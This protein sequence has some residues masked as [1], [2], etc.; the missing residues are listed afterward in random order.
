MEPDINPDNQV[1]TCPK[2][3]GF[4]T[5]A[6]GVTYMVSKRG[7]AKRAT[8]KRSQQPTPASD[9]QDCRPLTFTQAQGIEPLP[10]PLALEELSQHARTDLW[11]WLWSCIPH[12]DF[13]SAWGGLSAPEIEGILRL[14]YVELLHAPL[15]LF[16]GDVG[17]VPLI[18][19][20]IFLSGPYNIVFDIVQ[21]IL[22]NSNDESYYPRVRQILRQNMLAYDIIDI[23]PD[24]PTIVPNASPEEGEA[25]RE[26][27][28]VLRTGPFDGARHHLQQAASFINAGDA[29]K[30]VAQAMHAIESVVRVIAP[31]NNFNQALASLN[32]TSTIHPALKEALT[33]LYGYT[34]DEKGIRHPMLESDVARVHMP[35]AVFMYGACAAF[36]T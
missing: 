14:A 1:P 10:S 31:N 33:R 26:A 18:I 34:S 17:T 24:G 2:D 32:A 16:P 19:K 25:I 30:A 8:T 12:S 7:T 22:R 5:V 29:P 36:I 11:N 23:P 35:E 27:F 9:S 3:D 20:P 6:A 13:L 28:A 15:D 4:G 21:F